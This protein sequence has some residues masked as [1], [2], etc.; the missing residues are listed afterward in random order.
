[1]IYN[2]DDK[3]S[4]CCNNEDI[5][6]QYPYL[7]MELG[8]RRIY[9]ELLLNNYVAR[10]AL[11]EEGIPMVVASNNPLLDHRKYEVE[12]I[13]RRTE[14]LKSNIIA[15]NLFSQVYYYGR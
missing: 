7:D 9:E 5:G 6:L 13:N 12:Y 15:E 10:R 8:L 2:K 11:D 4:E 14:V 1:M 3:Y